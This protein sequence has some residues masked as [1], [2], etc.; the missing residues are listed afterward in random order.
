MA[1][2]K[3]DEKAA[4]KKSAKVVKDAAKAAT[5]R[6]CSCWFAC[7]GYCSSNKAAFKDGEE[8]ALRLSGPRE[9]V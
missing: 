2:E 4:A 3:E 9:G 6:C 1:A 8:A 5:T 7:R